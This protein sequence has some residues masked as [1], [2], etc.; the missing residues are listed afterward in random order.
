MSDFPNARPRMLYPSQMTAYHSLRT[1]RTVSE[2]FLH[3]CVFIPHAE[4]FLRTGG[5]APR[6]GDPYV[7][8]KRSTLF[9]RLLPQPFAPFPPPPFSPRQPTS[10]SPNLSRTFTFLPIYIYGRTAASLRHPAAKAPSSD[11]KRPGLFSKPPISRFTS[12]IF[13]AQPAEINAF[14]CGTAKSPR[15]HR[16][17]RQ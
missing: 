5:H 10:G 2:P 17:H 16:P 13:Q 9:R 3:F 11:K 4:L 12:A 6:Q 1:S 8:N 14:F 7:P 15:Q